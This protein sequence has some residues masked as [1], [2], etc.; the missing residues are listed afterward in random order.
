MGS[1]GRIDRE[2]YDADVVEHVMKGISTEPSRIGPRGDVVNLG[3]EDWLG[4]FIVSAV[5][6]QV[7]DDSEQE[8]PSDRNRS[9][10][11]RR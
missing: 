8:G 3:V 5:H 10:R 7:L 6:V 2:K 11:S 1:Q 9:R 4:G